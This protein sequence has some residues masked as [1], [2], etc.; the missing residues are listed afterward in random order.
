MSELNEDSLDRHF[1]KQLQMVSDV[2]IQSICAVHHDIIHHWLL[3]FYEA[4]LSDKYARNCLMVLMHEQLKVMGKLG[5]PFTDLANA[6][7]PLEEVLTKYE[8]EKQ[9]EPENPPI[10]KTNTESDLETNYT[11]YDGVSS[12]S[13]GKLSTVV[14]SSFNSKKKKSD[15]ELQ[16]EKKQQLLKQA[17]LDNYKESESNWQKKMN[18]SLQT[19]RSQTRL[20]KVESNARH[21]I[22][23]LKNWTP[24]SG[25]IN[26]LRITLQDIFD[27]EPET[28]RIL[29]DLDRKLER[30][31]EN[32]LEQ[33]GE[34]REKN[35]RILYDQLFKQQQDLLQAKQTLLE[36]EQQNLAKARQQLQAK[37][38][39]PYYKNMPTQTSF[40]VRPSQQ[41]QS[42]ESNTCSCDQCQENRKLVTPSPSPSPSVSSSS[43]F[44][45]IQGNKE[46]KNQKNCDCKFCQQFKRELSD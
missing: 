45:H 29:L 36:Q 10:A 35:V 27:D 37:E 20:Q 24:S 3:V 44:V 17:N 40:Y 13:S 34:R 46:L 1:A 38:Q 14:Q 26:L 16:L 12:R 39:A 30:E 11:S 2:F 4:P 8:S 23:R 5:K 32:L 41:P 19:L 43:L 18:Q 28:R 15:Y 31:L 22:R 6:K 42:K 25:S 21:A 7:L 33:A 9:S